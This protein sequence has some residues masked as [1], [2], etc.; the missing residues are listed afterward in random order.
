MTTHDVVEP[1]RNV[2][3]CARELR[4]Q[5]VDLVRELVEDGV[6]VEWVSKRSYRVAAAAF[7]G[8]REQRQKRLAERFQQDQR[9]AAYVRGGGAQ[10]PKRRAKFTR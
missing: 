1:M 8:W 6:K 4:M 2:R 3:D 10:Q 9:R 7:A 5:P